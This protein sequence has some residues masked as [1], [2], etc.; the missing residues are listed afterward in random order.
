MKLCAGTDCLQPS[1]E[2]LLDHQLKYVECFLQR[3][4]GPFAQSRIPTPRINNGAASNQSQTPV[5]RLH[6]LHTDQARMSRYGFIKP[7]A[8]YPGSAWLPL[9]DLVIELRF[10]IHRGNESDVLF[11][12]EAEG[13][14]TEAFQEV[15]E[16]VKSSQDDQDNLGLIPYPSSVQRASGVSEQGPLSPRSALTFRSGGSDVTLCH[17]RSGSRSPSP[18]TSVGGKINVN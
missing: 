17:R 14:L 13:I 8:T 10:T 4:R 11:P 15:K 9:M 3:F 12:S 7:G 18:E 1:G 16:R 2:S 6:W 5:S